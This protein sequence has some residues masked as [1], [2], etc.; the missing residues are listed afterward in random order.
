M[1]PGSPPAPV[2]RCGR[3]NIRSSR[4]PDW[5]APP[6]RPSGAAPDRPAPSYRAYERGQCASPPTGDRPCRG[7]ARIRANAAVR[8]GR[9]KRQQDQ[10]VAERRADF[11]RGNSERTKYSDPDKRRDAGYPGGHDDPEAPAPRVDDPRQRAEGSAP[12]DRSSLTGDRIRR[13]LARDRNFVAVATPAATSRRGVVLDQVEIVALLGPARPSSGDMDRR[14]ESARRAGRS[15]RYAPCRE[16]GCDRRR[17]RSTADA[18][19]SR[20]CDRPTAGRSPAGSPPR[21]RRRP[22]RAPSSRIRIGASRNKA[23]A[24]ARRWRW[25]PE[26]RTPRSPII[27][28]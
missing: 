9:C 7:R 3:K 16:P 13:R 25:P 5:P 17:S 6:G 10:Q 8:R 2:R 19:G 20:S 18:P 11:D 22:R 1:A 28:A 21:F 4:C 26:S 24:I 23:R 15:R 14:G 27:V 12:A